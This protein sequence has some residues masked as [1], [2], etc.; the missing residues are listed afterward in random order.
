[1]KE[2]ILNLYLVINKNFI[3]ELRASSYEMDGNDEEKIAFLKSKVEEDFAKSY[4]FEAP[5]NKKGVFLTYNK[6]Y[7]LEKTGKQFSVFEEVFER[8]E[9]PDA[10]LVCLTPVVDGKILS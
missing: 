10:P 7:K 2:K 3:T 5:K 4:I 8:F 9:V 6:F 1:M